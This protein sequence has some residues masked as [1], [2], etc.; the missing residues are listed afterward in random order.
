M[1]TLTDLVKIDAF[2]Y[3]KGM[4][5]YKNVLI[6]WDE[7]FNIILYNFIDSLGIDSSSLCAVMERKGRLYLL[8]HDVI[9]EKYQENKSLDVESDHF[10][11]V[12]YFD[13]LSDE[14]LENLPDDYEFPS[15]GPRN[16]QEQKFHDTFWNSYEKS[17]GY[18][19]GDQWDIVQSICL[20]HCEIEETYDLSQLKSV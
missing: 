5:I 13:F 6:L 10:F 19:P 8:W 11:E 1:F 12:D 14:E 2:E 18:F 17:Y 4:S 9:P 7:D 15:H 16:E 20:S 3:H